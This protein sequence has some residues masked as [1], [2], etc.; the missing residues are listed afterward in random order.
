MPVDE[1]H[2]EIIFCVLN[3]H[4][5]K[6]FGGTWL[7]SERDQV[8]VLFRARGRHAFNPPFDFPLYPLADGGRI[9]S[10]QLIA[11]RLVSGMLPD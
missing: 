2:S 1:Y 6:Y 4:Y 10:D 8:S 3:V 9:L 11:G 7:S 5:K